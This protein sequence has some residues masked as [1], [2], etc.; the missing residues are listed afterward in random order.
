ML[1]EL[2][3]L[4]YV[5]LLR[6]ENVDHSFLYKTKYNWIREFSLD[7]QT[8]NHCSRSVGVR[9]NYIKEARFKYFIV[10]N[11]HN[12]DQ[13]LPN[14]ALQINKLIFS[15]LGTDNVYISIYESGSSDYTKEYLRQWSKLLNTNKVRHHFQTETISKT[16]QMNRIDYLARVRNKALDPLK[17]LSNIVFDHS[18]FLN[19]ILFC[20]DDL[21]ELIHQRIFQN[22][23]MVA[24][25]DFDMKKDR[26]G[27]YDNWV[28]RDMNG[29]IPHFFIENLMTDP[30]SNIDIQMRDPTQVICI[31]NGAVVIDPQ[32]F[33]ETIFFRRGNNR[34][35]GLNKPGECSASEITTFCMDMIRNG[36][37]KVVLVPTVH[38]VYNMKDFKK[39]K[40]GNDPLSKESTN[41]RIQTKKVQFRPLPQSFVCEPY[42]DH[43]RL[44]GPNKKLSYK[45]AIPPRIVKT[46]VF[47]RPLKFSAS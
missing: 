42:H 7:F 9:Y 23:S 46:K 17:Y 8:V 34:E 24:G 19:D 36:F 11:L 33:H 2:S 41:V 30:K 5:A 21:L 45:E 26:L 22:A 29:E 40:F 44:N 39:L 35:P 16:K 14:M 12:S 38:V 27:F 15:W 37:D 10:L 20:V 3:I 1:F 31:W 25:L 32:I 18:I 47:Q 28:M 43:W 4:F 13:I 6:F